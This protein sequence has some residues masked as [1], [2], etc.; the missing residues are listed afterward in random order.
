MYIPPKAIFTRNVVVSAIN[1]TITLIIL[2]IAPLGLAAVIVNTFL[3]TASTF[4]VCTAVDWVVLW[5]LPS[6]SSQN[7]PFS[8]RQKDISYLDST[9]DLEIRRH[10]RWQDGDPRK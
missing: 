5:L 3:V 9:K 4:I 8:K 2:L 1:G 10:N 7:F 6:S